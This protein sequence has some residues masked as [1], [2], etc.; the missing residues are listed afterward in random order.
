MGCNMQGEAACVNMQ[1]FS[2]CGEGM[3]AHKS[4]RWGS[5]TRRTA[6]TA[7]GDSSE[8]YC[9]TTLLLSDLRMRAQAALIAC[10]KSIC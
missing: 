8:L 5:S 2:G 6:S 1:Q 9:D 10:G 4:G 7:M 3:S